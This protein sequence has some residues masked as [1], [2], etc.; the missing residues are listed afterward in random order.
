MEAFDLPDPLDG[1][2]DPTSQIP[3]TG[4]ES[5][6]IKSIVERDI[7]KYGFLFFAYQVLNTAQR[8]S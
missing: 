4:K 8:V 3:L 2:M 1:I 6:S 5:S 7:T